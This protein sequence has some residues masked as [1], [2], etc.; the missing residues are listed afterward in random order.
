M[1]AAAF[2]SSICYGRGEKSLPFTS[3]EYNSSASFSKRSPISN[4]KY[5]AVVRLKSL[6]GRLW[7]NFENEKR[8]SINDELSSVLR[9]INEIYSIDEPLPLEIYNAVEDIAIYGSLEHG[10]LNMFYFAFCRSGFLSRL[11]RELKSICATTKSYEQ[12][13]SSIKLENEFNVT[14]MLCYLAIMKKCLIPSSVVQTTIPSLI[15][16]LYTSGDLRD[17]IKIVEHILVVFRNLAQHFETLKILRSLQI[18]RQIMDMIIHFVVASES[19]SHFDAEQI[20]I[21]SSIST[22][23]KCNLCW[24]FY[25]CGG[26]NE[27]RVNEAGTVEIS[28]MV[29]DVLATV[30]E[31][32]NESAV[33]ALFS[34]ENEALK[35]HLP[36]DEAEIVM[37]KQQQLDVKPSCEE[38]GNMFHLLGSQ[39]ILDAFEVPLTESLVSVIKELVIR[40][41]KEQSSKKNEEKGNEKIDECRNEMSSNEFAE[42][43]EEEEEEEKNEDVIVKSEISEKD[44]DQLEDGGVEH[45]KNSTENEE[46]VGEG[47][48]FWT[49]LK[50]DLYESAEE[51]GWSDIVDSLIHHQSK[52]IQTSTTQHIR[53]FFS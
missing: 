51:D 5:M 32:G 36:A 42:M 14:V 15:K 39:W 52:L 10:Q 37:P 45:Q 9:E 31:E 38:N 12:D 35:C 17:K 8:A 23:A 44:I 26:W 18:D 47:K 1:V 43:K 6:H 7:V 20:D 21:F 28:R 27:N 4:R 25:Y 19:E 49:N 34:S 50:D 11:E 13:I 48:S 29:S 46:L 2:S 30:L 53:P 3:D 41:Q 33:K 40:I 16:H 22:S 24:I